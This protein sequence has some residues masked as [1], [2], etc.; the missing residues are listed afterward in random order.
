MKRNIL[1]SISARTQ[2]AVDGQQ[3][4]YT[5]AKTNV[6]TVI[7]AIVNE[8]YIEVDKLGTKVGSVA[9]KAWI[10]V[11]DISKPARGDLITVLDGGDSFIVNQSES[12]QSALHEIS[13]NKKV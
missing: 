5:V 11:D 13:L 7:T 4:A 8:S 10:H 9:P 12:S 3:C 2:L 6:T 1:A